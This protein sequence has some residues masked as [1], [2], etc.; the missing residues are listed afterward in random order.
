MGARQPAELRMNRT[1]GYLDHAE[2]FS[3]ECDFADCNGERL[4]RARHD[5]KERSIA[6]RPKIF[7]RPN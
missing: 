1:P 5:R 7:V 3:G 4:A 6:R 2:A